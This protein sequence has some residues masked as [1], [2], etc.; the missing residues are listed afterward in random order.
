MLIA[1]LSAC[2]S[3][4]WN[5]LLTYSHVPIF[6]SLNNYFFPRNH[7]L[8]ALA[9]SRSPLF[10][11][12]NLFFSTFLLAYAIVYFTLISIIDFI[13]THKFLEGRICIHL[14][15]YPPLLYIKSISFLGCHNKLSQTSWFKATEIYSL[16]FGGHKS[17][18]KVSSATHPPEAPGETLSL[19]LPASVGSRCSLSC[20][21]IIQTLL[22]SPH[23][24]QLPVSP[25]ISNLPLLSPIRIPVVGFR[26]YSRS[27]VISSPKPSFNYKDTS[28]KLHDI[29]RLQG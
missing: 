26:V 5:M 8:I 3:S 14:S 22:P 6:T 29:H 7:Y 12:Q 21:W 25:C 20:E 16:S 10:S 23:D 9:W 19:P 2:R 15:F 27:R 28:S 17:Q 24:L 13:L 1:F 4:I 11:H 18:T